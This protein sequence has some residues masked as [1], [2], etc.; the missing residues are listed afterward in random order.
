MSTSIF[1]T[2]DPHLD[3][4]KNDERNIIAYCGRPFS[5]IDE[6]NNAIVTRWNSVVKKADLVY[7]L[8]DLA[9][10][11]HAMWMNELNGSKI[12]VFGN[13]DKMPMNVYKNFTR[14]YGD[15]NNSGIHQTT[16]DK[17]YVVMSHYPMASWNASFHGSWNFRGHAHGRRRE[18]LEPIECTGYDAD[19]VMFGHDDGE[20][21]PPMRVPEYDESMACAVDMDVW[22]FTPVPWEVL[23]AKMQ[24]R[25]PAWKER[26]ERLQAAHE[27]LPEYPRKLSVANRGWRDKCDMQVAPDL[28]K[29]DATEKFINKVNEAYDKTANSTLHFGGQVIEGPRLQETYDLSGSSIGQAV[30]AAWAK[31]EALKIDREIRTQLKTESVTGGLL[32][33]EPNANFDP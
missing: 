16:I 2:S 27:A 23:K 15:P 21:A 30:L 12:M 6:M 1:I 10:K 11:R 13:H 19:K 24:A 3:H 9:W 8:G 20:D 29:S 22:D 17:Q 14:Y 18:V 25:I 26:R 31:D 5:T 4:W 28:I 7:I 33:N 32:G